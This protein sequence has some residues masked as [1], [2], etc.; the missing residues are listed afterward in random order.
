[1]CSPP[2]SRHEPT[3]SS[4]GNVRHFPAE[5]CDPFAIEVQTP[6]E[7]LAYSFDLAPDVMTAVF[8][9]QV[10]EFTR[11]AFSLKEALSKLDERLPSLAARLR[12][13]LPPP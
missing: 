3:L 11:P 8:L 7:F 9:A 10:A 6:D 4:R 13:A 1:M 12:K 5:S 2:R